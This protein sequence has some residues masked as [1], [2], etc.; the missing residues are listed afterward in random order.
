MTQKEDHVETQ[1]GTENFATSNAAL[2]IVPQGGSEQ[3][4]TIA[5]S[6]RSGS[7]ILDGE[8][9]KK[10]RKRMNNDMVPSGKRRR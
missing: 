2:P 4:G 7:V 3:T 9:S 6:E 5:P 1:E 10:K 8:G